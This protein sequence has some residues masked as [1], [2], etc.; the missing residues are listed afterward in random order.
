MRQVAQQDD[1]IARAKRYR[2][3][4]IEVQIAVAIEHQ[5]K[6]AQFP[7][8]RGSAPAA[9]V[10][11]HMQDGGVERIDRGQQGGVNDAAELDG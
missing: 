2:R 8:R 7:A 5:V 9:A 4:A 3:R 10:L 1:A 6:A 11:A